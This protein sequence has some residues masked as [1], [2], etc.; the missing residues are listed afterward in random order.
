MAY[1]RVGGLLM[2]SILTMAAAGGEARQARFSVPVVDAAWTGGTRAQVEPSAEKTPDGEPTVVVRLQHP[3]ARQERF[4]E[5]NSL[6]LAVGNSRPDDKADWRVG[7]AS[8]WLRPVVLSPEPLVAVLRRGYGDTVALAKPGWRRV[9]VRSW[10]PA[11]LYLRGVDQLSFRTALPPEGTAFQIGPVQ[12]Q[13]EEHLLRWRPANGGAFAVHGLWWL[14]E[15]DGAYRRLPQRVAKV[16]AG[17]WS[18]AQRPAGGRV[19]FRTNSATLRLRVDHG[20]DSFPWPVMSSMAMAGIELYEGT[21]GKTVFRWVATP[22]SAKEPYE[23]RPPIAADG[24]MHEYTLY[25]PMYA[26]LASLDIGLDPEARIEPPTAFGNAKPVVFYGT[27][28]VQGGCASRGSMNFPAIVGRKL[29]MD[30]INLGF[31]GDGQCEPEIADCMAEI[32]ASCFV[33]GPILS[34]LPLMRERY[35][36]FVARLREKWP[37]TPIL[38]MTRLHTVGRKTPYPVNQLVQEVHAARRAAGDRNIHLFDAFSLYG[39]GGFY[40][41][42]D[43]VHPTDYGFMLIGN[44]L[45]PALAKIL[46]LPK[47]Q[48]AGE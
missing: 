47:P 18:A 16:N 41:T 44:A 39:D 17:V 30:I 40:P 34:N 22:V 29:G 11:P 43:G 7:S 46:G 31:A 1:L 24:K 25:L 28:F 15:N 3:P 12:F 14:K 33:M 42:A 35:A 9:E 6:V 23:L 20:N 19:R 45:A 26:K 48:P 38:L 2:A 27:S 10:G 32:E 36:P 21:P 8:F 37:E 4:S 5:K 13:I